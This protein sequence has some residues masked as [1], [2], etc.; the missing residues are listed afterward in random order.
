VGG[1]TKLGGFVGSEKLI[2]VEF[3]ALQDGQGIISLHNARILLHDGL[4]TDAKLKETINSIVTIQSIDVPSESIVTP[5]ETSTNYM[6]VK[7]PPTT[8]LNG[9]GNQTFSDISI[10]IINIAS[11]N[12]RFD[13]NLDGE[14]DGAD[15]KILRE[16][17]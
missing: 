9:D 17:R 1:T 11:D 10:F 6:V 15:L 14:V 16:M 8:D 3:V 7:N 13:F 4:G 5:P 12:P 2:R